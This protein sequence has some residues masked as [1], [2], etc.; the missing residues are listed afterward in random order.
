MTTPLLRAIRRADIVPIILLVALSQ[1]C[2][3]KSARRA[4]LEAEKKAAID[5]VIEI[6]NQP[7]EPLIR[8][9]DM[10]VSVYKPGWFHEGAGK[11]SFND[12]DVRTTQDTHYGKHRYVT[13]DLNPG[14][15]W[16][17]PEVEFNSNTKYFYEDRSVPK[18]RLSEEEMVE[19]NRLYRIIGR[20]EQELA[21][22]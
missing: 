22:L 19:I 1:S 18:K 10:P 16:R 5:A 15:A 2:A 6:V 14:L 8:A 13:S 12:V 9:A 21:D 11:P 7:V 17:G 3:D 4:A 20:C